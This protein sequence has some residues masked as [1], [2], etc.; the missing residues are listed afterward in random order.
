MASLTKDQSGWVILYVNRDGKRRSFYPGKMPKKAAEGVKRHLEQLLA[1]EKARTV[2][3]GETVAWVA[4]CGDVMRLKLQKHGLIDTPAVTS[5]A[6]TIGEFT[7]SYISRRGDVTSSTKQ[8]WRSSRR[9]LLLFFGADRLVESIGVGDAKDFRQWMLR[10]GRGPGRGSAENTVRKVCSIAGQFYSDA[11]DRGLVKVNPFVHRDVPR[12]MRENRTRDFFITRD[13]AERILAA[14]PD[15]W[16]RLSFSLSRFGGLRCPS[17]HAKLRWTDIKWDEG[18]I[19]VTSPKTERH[20][21]KGS[22]IIPLFPELRPL[23]QSLYDKAEDKGGFVFPREEVNES[24]IRFRLLSTLN[25]LGIE[26]WPKLF[27]NLRATR[28]TELAA[29]FPIDVV[30]KWIGHS[31]LVASRNYLQV[32]DEDFRRAAGNPNQNPNQHTPETAGNARQSDEQRRSPGE[33]K[34][35]ISSDFIG[36]EKPSRRSIQDSAFDRS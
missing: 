30:C 21:G 9:L 34:P 14:C 33:V 16:I 25:R 11:V 28:E 4:N 18:R 12:T 17:E 31:I 5:K 15:D 26:P 35:K 23:L 2:V 22:R 27:H 10:E 13:T 29:E 3:P 7:A 32:R 1:A 6:V 36:R 19:V 24:S 20:S 8:K